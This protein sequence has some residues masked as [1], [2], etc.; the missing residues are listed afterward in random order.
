MQFSDQDAPVVVQR[1]VPMVLLTVQMQFSDKDAECRLF[2]RQVLKTVEVPQLQFIDVEDHGGSQLQCIDKG[3]PS[4]LW[5]RG[6]S[7]W[8][9]A[10][11]GAVVD[12]PVVVQRQV[13]GMAELAIFFADTWSAAWTA[14]QRLQ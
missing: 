8:S 3:S 4:L 5:R 7:P 1:H 12:A 6:K 10:V 9:S 14:T 13:P 2:A 11:L